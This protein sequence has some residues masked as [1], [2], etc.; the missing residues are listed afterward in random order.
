MKTTLKISGMSC[1]H[2]VKHVTGALEGI[3][4]VVSA[5]VSLEH[6]SAEVEHTDRV[7]PEAMKAAIVEAGYEVI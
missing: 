1:E 5:K 3:N 7:S 4:G 2:C 6:N